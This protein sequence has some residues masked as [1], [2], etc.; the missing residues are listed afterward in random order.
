[1]LMVLFFLRHPVYTA[2]MLDKIAEGRKQ[3]RHI[4]INKISTDRVIFLLRSDS[5]ANHNTCLYGEKFYLLY[6]SAM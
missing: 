4:A 1:M 2:T 6:V 5:A 3:T